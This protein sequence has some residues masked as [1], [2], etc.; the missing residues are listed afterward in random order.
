MTAPPTAALAT[1]ADK[2][3]PC[4]G[5]KQARALALLADENKSLAELIPILAQDPGLAIALLRHINEKRRG[6]GNEVTTLD[7][8]LGLMGKASV[9]RLLKAVPSIE[10]LTQ[11]AGQV[12]TYIQLCWRSF[13]ASQQASQ[14]AQQRKDR[15]PGEAAMTA[16][17]FYIG[18]LALCAHDYSRFGEIAR[19]SAGQ[20]CSDRCAEQRVVGTSLLELGRQ[21]GMHWGLADTTLEAFD[22]MSVFNPRAVAVQLAA[23]LARQSER[24]WF[25]EAMGHCLVVASDLLGQPEE[26]VIRD[27]HALAV[28]L[29]DRW[30]GGGRPTTAG[31]IWPTESRADQASETAPTP[32]ATVAPPAPP[33]K[34][35]NPALD[36]MKGRTPSEVLQALVKGLRDMAGLHRALFLLIN[37][38]RT[39]LL[40]RFASG[41]D[42]QSAL[43]TTALKLKDGRLFEKL[44]EKP[45]GV[46]LNPDNYERLGVG[47]PKALID[48]LRSRDIFIMSVFVGPRAI[49]FVITDAEGETLAERDYTVFKQLSLIASRRLTELKNAQ[50]G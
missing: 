1:L 49:G 32:A 16:Q 43:A 12:E 39:Q 50:K 9:E 38:D 28:T 35:S 6:S 8:A 37:P 33:A 34:K 45:T 22:P 41:I 18:E 23:E 5:A 36:V 11:D 13:H 30:T 15:S 19:T 40:P 10:S 46:W 17:C 31:L 4:V 7:S 25:S 3:L 26:R 29:A 27:V 24:G 14:W 42:A 20:R 44:M 47:L 48:G 2:A 21:L